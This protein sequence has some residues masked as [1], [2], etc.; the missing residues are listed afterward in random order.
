[1][2]ARLHGK[3]THALTL[4]EQALTQKLPPAGSLART[5]SLQAERS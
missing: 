2:N 4:I 1:M 3:P 5:A